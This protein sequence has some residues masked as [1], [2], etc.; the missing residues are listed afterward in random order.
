MRCGSVCI[1]ACCWAVGVSVCITEQEAPESWF[2]K[3]DTGLVGFS[4][5][6]RIL[7]GN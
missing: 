2:S 7:G 6:C 1:S 4:G 5:G 3:V